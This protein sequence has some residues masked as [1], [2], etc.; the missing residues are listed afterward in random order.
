MNKRFDEKLHQAALDGDYAKVAELE[1][2]QEE[3]TTGKKVNPLETF[4]ESLMRQNTVGL[5]KSKKQE[6][7]EKKLSSK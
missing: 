3:D 2:Q 6:K 4:G 1:A 5:S 7:L